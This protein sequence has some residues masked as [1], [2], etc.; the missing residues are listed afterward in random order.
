MSAVR[1]ITGGIMTSIFVIALIVFAVQFAADNESEISL[2]NDSNFEALNTTLRSQ[3]SDIKD[4]SGIVQ[5]IFLK[6]T[7]EAGD[8]HASGGGQFKIGPLKAVSLAISSFKTAFNTIFGSEFAFIAL[9]F[10]S[11]MTILLSYFL[12]KAWLGRTPD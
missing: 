6:T 3:N 8:E 2:L 9:T 5:S 1:F 11:L 10:A 7:L 12:Y 4:N